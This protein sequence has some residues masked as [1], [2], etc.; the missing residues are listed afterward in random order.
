M[1]GSTISVSK[2]LLITFILQ[3]WILPSFSQGDDIFGIERKI[4]GRKSNNELGN[5]FRNMISNFSFEISG[6]SAYHSNLMEFYSDSANHYPFSPLQEEEGIG[7]NLE[8]T[9]SLRGGQMV[10]PINVGVRLKLFNFL[11]LGAGY[12]REWGQMSALNSTAFDFNFDGQK[13]IIDRLYG[14]VGMVLWDADKR[15]SFLK[16]R[17][18]NFSENN[19]YMQSELKLRAR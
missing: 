1:N 5:V 11:T 12:G 9:L 14:T 18:T 10:M 19:I 7:L 16:W 8:D 3:V 4:S 2:F 15:I 6:G 13:Y 17:Y